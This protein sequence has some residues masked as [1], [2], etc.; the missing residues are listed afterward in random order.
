MSRGHS[1][2]ASAAE[3]VPRF[4]AVLSRCHVRQGEVVLLHT[5]TRADP[6][7][8]AAALAAA[9]ELDASPYQLTVP[10]R[11]P[12]VEQ[13]ETIARAWEEAD[14]VIDLVSTGAHLFS[15]LNT[16]AVEAG[17]RVLRISEPADVLD[18]MLPSEDVRQRTRL[19][20]DRLTSGQTLTVASD[21]G[22]MLE[23]NIAGRDGVAQ[24]GLAD[25]SGRWDHWPSGLA[26]IAPVEDTVRGRLVVGTGD[27]VFTLGRYVREPIEC[28]VDRGVVTV[29]GAG[30]DAMIL[31]DWLAAQEASRAS[32]VGVIGWGTDFRARWDRVAW[33]LHEPAGTMDAE[34]FAGNVRVGL[35]NNASSML[36]GRNVCRSHID[37]QLRG[38]T[39]A[40]D[41]EAVVDAGGLVDASR[42]A[43][44]TLDRKEQEV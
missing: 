25:E 20:A 6:E 8:T 11:H 37:L 4:R 39:V 18:R 16:R 27:L 42:P 35:G 21:S 17:T 22:T 2:A 10:T 13:L 38:C 30:V 44:P 28:T 41:G 12:N 1:T 15:P 14:L 5:D 9:L 31:R 33:H 34:S 23:M 24:Y 3:L 19:Y 29:D 7:Y 43:S 36:R 40:I 32:V 26:Q